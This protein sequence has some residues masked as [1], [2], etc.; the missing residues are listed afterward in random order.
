MLHI[1]LLYINYDASILNNLRIIS[2]RYFITYIF[3]KLLK[4]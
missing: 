3:Y 2:K 4:F 1:Y